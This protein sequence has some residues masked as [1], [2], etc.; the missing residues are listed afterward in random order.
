MRKRFSSRKISISCSGVSVTE[1][2]AM[3]R[4]V[5]ISQR[6]VCNTSVGLTVVYGA[7]LNYVVRSAA[8]R[9]AEY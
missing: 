1:S 9:M 3:V 7:V 4:E 5:L 2:D 8:A 6:T